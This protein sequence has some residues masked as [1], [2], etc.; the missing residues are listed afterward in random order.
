M[1]GIKCGLNIILEGHSMR[2]REQIVIVNFGLL[3]VAKNY[4]T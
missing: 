4:R 3:N 1:V 2:R